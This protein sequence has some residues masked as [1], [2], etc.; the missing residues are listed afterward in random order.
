MTM[1]SDV[2]V[3]ADAAVAAGDEIG[4]MKPEV[5]HPSFSP[6][7]GASFDNYQDSPAVSLAHLRSSRCCRV[8]TSISSVST[9]TR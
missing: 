4:A 9:A 5:T 8:R 1:A 3:V 6:T 7:Q 2:A